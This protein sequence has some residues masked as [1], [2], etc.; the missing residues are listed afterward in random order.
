MNISRPYNNQKTRGQAM[1]E[2]AL[3]LPI[4]LTLLYGLLETGRL[5]FIYASTV[6]AA[7]QAVRY[8]SATGIG[9]NGVQ[10]YQDCD[11]IEA[12]AN[13]VGFI[14][15]FEDI[16]ISY[17]GGLDSN[18]GNIVPLSPANPA[19]GSFTEVKNGDRIIVTVSSQWI[20]IV[21]IVPLEPFT[22]TSQSERTIL[23]SVSISV[24]SVPQGWQS[25]GN[26]ILT[27]LSIAGSP[28]PYSAVGQATYTY[29]LKN[30]G[31]GELAGPFTVTDSIATTNCSGAAAS[32]AVGAETTC[33]G[34]YPITQADL[35]AGT[36]TNQA[37]GYANG[38][39]SVNSPTEIIY[40]AA[41]PTLN[42][43]KSASPIAA[44]SA[45]TNIT[46]T[47]T[48]GNTG[49]VTLISPYT[50]ADNKIAGVNCS[51]AAS[52][53]APGATTTCTA[54]Y[55]ITDAD[56]NNGSVVNQA[57]ASA[58]FKTTTVTSNSASAT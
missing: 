52:P 46:Y 8:G 38:S 3:A 53:L 12:A 19:C 44:S 27:L 4:L 7:R 54:S 18:N 31:S 20:P 56:I 41:T 13:N 25:S 47:Y 22:I 48:L 40:A 42:L 17:D 33:T 51:G 43:S 32:L 11:G 6:T 35:D 24:T 21:S 29:T 39:P 55:S 14:N 10:Y 16:T 26:G 28:D 15:T 58:K 36:V 9:P 1:V 34:T 23:A 37:T 57:V 30:T 50:V 2:F 5:L 45:G 49:N